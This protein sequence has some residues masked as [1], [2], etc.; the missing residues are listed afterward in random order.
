MSIVSVA[1]PG[2][3]LID[4]WTPDHRYF[5]EA[6]SAFV[7]ASYTGR[8]IQ[9]EDR[10]TFDFRG[11]APTNRYFIC[12]VWT[13]LLR[14]NLCDVATLKYAPLFSDYDTDVIQL[15]P[16][17]GRS[18]F[19]VQNDDSTTDIYVADIGQT[20]T[21]PHVFAR[22]NGDFYVGSWS[23]DGHYL[24]IFE[25]PDSR[26]NYLLIDV[27]SGEMQSLNHD[28][29]IDADYLR[30]VVWSPDS[31]KLAFQDVVTGDGPYNYAGPLYVLVLTTG[32]LTQISGEGGVDPRWS[33]DGSSLLFDQSEQ[34]P[35]GDGITIV[36]HLYA[37]NADGSNRVEIV[38]NAGAVW[39]PNS[40][41]V[42]LTSQGR[43]YVAQREG[44][45][46]PELVADF[47]PWGVKAFDGI[48]A[49]R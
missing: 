36:H 33:P 20:I 26:Y 13:E 3:Y 32:R 25:A 24:L 22:L 46:S 17:N 9:S 12:S 19:A 30:T 14:F 48:A 29:G 6:V 39:L 43:V 18:A 28:Y 8:V 23:P 47:T 37:V 11:G 45:Q 7:Y 21:T 49:W 16:D 1:L 42:I 34:Q 31:S 44:N 5:A 35:Y 27:D 40:E 38:Q 41:H 10:A 2:N 15:A 4:E